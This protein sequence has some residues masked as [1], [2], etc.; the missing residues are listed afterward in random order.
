[1]HHIE[2]SPYG[3]FKDGTTVWFGNLVDPFL[4]EEYGIANG[5]LKA[6]LFRANITGPTIRYGLWLRKG[7]D[8]AEFEELLVSHVMDMRR[9]LTGSGLARKEK[10]LEMLVHTTGQGLLDS[11]VS[12]DD[13]VDADGKFD[14]NAWYDIKGDVRP[15]EADGTSS[16]LGGTVFDSLSRTPGTTMAS[17]LVARLGEPMAWYRTTVPTSR[18]VATDTGYSIESGETQ[19]AWGPGDSNEFTLHPR[20]T[21]AAGADHD[22]DK[23]HILTQWADPETG[24]VRQWDGDID[25]IVADAK[26]EYDNAVAKNPKR[27]GSPRGTVSEAQEDARAKLRDKIFGQFQ[28]T[29]MNRVLGTRRS[30]IE[31]LI[32]S[33]GGDATK[34]A[35]APIKTSIFSDA[36][37]ETFRYTYYPP[38]DPRSD[39]RLDRLLDDPAARERIFKDPR[40]AGTTF[41]PAYYDA[42]R[43]SKAPV[44]LKLPA[45]LHQQMAQGPVAAGAEDTLRAL[46]AKIERTDRS[47]AGRAIIVAAMRQFNSAFQA[48]LRMKLGAQRITKKGEAEKFPAGVLFGIQNTPMFPEMDI[49]SGTPEERLLSQRL[50]NSFGCTVVQM[51][52]DA[53]KA[54]FPD[55][56]AARVNHGWFQLENVLAMGQKFKTPADV[57]AF[58][59][60]F[61]SWTWSPMAEAYTDHNEEQR[62]PD[63]KRI[64]LITV[65]SHPIF[66]KND[67]H[68]QRT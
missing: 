32:S 16:Y 39:H 35:M 30:S 4:T 1:V 48:G 28:M 66:L 17:H 47:V 56:D 29:A 11:R 12:F 7:V 54:P 31:K 67:L 41:T 68:R 46:D 23:R 10:L 2:V 33:D 37:T 20:Y 8:R 36:G 6:P 21:M 34:T 64:P 57:L 53:L 26:L 59:D 14:A 25:K 60:Q 50:W 65:K 44:S 13:L 58:H 55:L 63:V 3:A 5:K 45:W 22:G 52:I 15:D 19:E 61:M 40:L 9:G 24:V 62:R 18:I 38:G 51:S 42:L 43:E 27:Y 49:G